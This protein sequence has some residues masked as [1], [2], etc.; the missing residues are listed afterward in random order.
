MIKGRTA[1]IER[2]SDGLYIGLVYLTPVFRG[3]LAG[4][5]LGHRRAVILGA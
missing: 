5:V 1:M 3:M 2:L 4:R